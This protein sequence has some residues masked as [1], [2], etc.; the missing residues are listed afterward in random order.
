[1]GDLPAFS[2]IEIR[3]YNELEA[4]FLKSSSILKRDYLNNLASFQV[5]PVPGEIEAKKMSDYAQF[6]DVT[7]LVYNKEESFIEKLITIARTSHICGYSLAIVIKS[8]GEKTNFW[9]GSVNK[10]YD[11]NMTGIMAETLKGS[12]EGNFQ[13][14]NLTLVDNDLV[15]KELEEFKNN[16]VVSAVSNVASLRDDN[17]EIDKYIQGIE[18]LIDSLQGR[19]Y[20][21]I[22]IADPISNNESMIVKDS[23]E[24]LYSQLSG[25]ATTEM[26]MNENS[27]IS[28]SEQYSKSFSHTIGTN[29]SVSQSHTNQTGWSTGDS[30]TEG[31]STNIGAVAVAVAGVAAVGLTVATGGLGA[32]A[33]AA[34]AGTAVSSTAAAGAI[35]AGAITAAGSAAGGLIGSKSKSKTTSSNKSGSQSDTSSKQIGENENYTDGE[36][37]TTSLAKTIGS[38]RTLSFTVENRTVKSL[39]EN[40]DTQIERFKDCGSYGAFCACTYILSEDINVNML[41]SGLFNALTSGKNSNIQVSKVN[42]WGIEGTQDDE[43]NSATVIGYLSKLT[44]PRFAAINADMEFTPASLVSGK[45]LSIQLGFPKHSIQG[46][47]VVYKV[48]FGRNV[49]SASDNKK[50]L[51]IGRISNMGVLDSREIVLDANSLNSHLFVTGSTGAGKSN[52]VYKLLE[53]ITNI[54]SNI[55]FMVVEPA[56][57]EYKHAF[58]NHKRIKTEVYGTNPKKSRL[59]KV[60]PFSFPQDIHVLEHVDRIVEILNVCWPMYAAMPAILKNAV[61]KSYEKC[62]WDVINSY[63]LGSETVYPSFADVLECIKEILNKS[64]FSDDNKGDYTGA[65]CTRVESLTM[66]INGQI[67]CVDEISDKELFDENIIVDLSRV[68]AAETKSLIMGILVMKLQEYRMASALEPNQDLKHIMVLE[69]AHNLLKKTSTEQSAESSNLVGKSVEMITNAIA[70]MRTYGEGFFIVDQAPNLLDTAAIRNTNT[71]IVLRLPEEQDRTIVGKSMAL[72]EDQITELSKLEKGCA[73]IYQNDWEEAVLCQFDQYHKDYD[74]VF[75]DN[76]M[77]EYHVNSKILT[78]SDMK[79]NILRYLLD[80]TVGEAHKFESEELRRLEKQIEQLVLDYSIKQSVRKI[81]TD[82]NKH[83]L[84]E[85]TDIV[86]ELYPCVGVIEKVKNSM[87]IE[88]WNENIICTIDPNLRFMS[89]WYMD[90][91]VQC[92]L[93][94]YVKLN[95]KFEPYVEKWTRHMEGVK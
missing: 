74:N 9:I 54:D 66:G 87:N 18:K 14:S 20:S 42:S 95:P 48:P 61:I 77:F 72:S 73:V 11:T 40:I 46:L 62:G 31:K 25:F 39:L 36:N 21:L 88:D 75:L 19:A 70:E 89:K 65:L 64:A 41:A 85:I 53:Q 33:G 10:I 55:H 50:P 23:L 15:N 35:G 91:F 12:V 44:H 80:T 32:V 56:K 4:A 1:M 51:H 68:G 71:K 30:Y 90:T 76:E 69:E 92:V 59:L 52:V 7:K 78:Q 82:G 43:A 79:K 37:N 6:F 60:N 83:S 3:E 27:N 58:Y 94:K 34:I 16:S 38:G 28:N 8:D 81:I 93:L 26:S 67:F 86:T 17:Q 49:I 24:Q 29:T 47:S 5:R 45:E 63:N 57:G 22:T 2:E 13:G 84:E